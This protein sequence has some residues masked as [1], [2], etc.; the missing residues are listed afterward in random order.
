MT[1]RIITPGPNKYAIVDSV[2]APSVQVPAIFHFRMVNRRTPCVQKSTS[3]RRVFKSRA[4]V[5]YSLRRGIQAEFGRNSAN[6]GV[7]GSTSHAAAQP[8]AAQRPNEQHRSEQHEERASQ[9]RGAAR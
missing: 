9:E 7:Q 6:D 8:R 3:T 1:T 4:N 2:T 5:F